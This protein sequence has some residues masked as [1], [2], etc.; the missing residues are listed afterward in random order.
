MNCVLPI[1]KLDVNVI[2]L[3][4]PAK[5]TKEGKR[6]RGPHLKVTSNYN[7]INVI[8]SFQSSRSLHRAV[9]IM[10]TTMSLETSSV[11]STKQLH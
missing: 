1:Q 3:P 6:D 5:G 2:L 7:Q 9:D 10:Q 8:P 4:G 11:P